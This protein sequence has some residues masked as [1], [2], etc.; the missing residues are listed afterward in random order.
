MLNNSNRNSNK[1]ESSNEVNFTD[2][3]SEKL[4]LIT[5]SFIRLLYYF[6]D[7]KVI[8]NNLFTG[9]TFYI[10]KIIMMMYLVE[11]KSLLLE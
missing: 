6:I 9:N 8:C 3:I 4:F 5:Y 7:R 1:F 11:K 2:L 10:L